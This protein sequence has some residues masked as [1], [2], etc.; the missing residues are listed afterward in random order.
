MRQPHARRSRGGA[1]LNDSEHSAHGC[2][3]RGTSIFVVTRC[4]SGA[5]VG[6]RCG[7]SPSSSSSSSSSS[8]LR[9]SPSSSSS[10]ATSS[11]PSAASSATPATGTTASD[12]SLDP[13]PFSRSRSY[14]APANSRSRSFFTANDRSLLPFFVTA[15]FFRCD[16][17]CKKCRSSRSEVMDSDAAC[18]DDA[19]DRA[20]ASSAPAGT[21]TAPP[22]LCCSLSR[23][24]SP[25]ASYR[26]TVISLSIASTI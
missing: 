14:R 10:P 26:Y 7:R 13:A 8:D 5:R 12:A 11:S 23:F 1:T 15:I 6:K 2:D 9:S 19:P 4:T 16:S 18:V 24:L 17:V 3:S 22:R 20:P 21:S 25:S